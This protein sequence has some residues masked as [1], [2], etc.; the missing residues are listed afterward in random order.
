M[1]RPRTYSDAPYLEIRK[2]SK[3]G[4]RSGARSQR[5]PIAIS[6]NVTPMLQWPEDDLTVV[7]QYVASSVDQTS[8]CD[9]GFSK[10]RSASRGTPTCLRLH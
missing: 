4:C 10:I 5:R 1:R 8:R 9:V 2:T 6:G 3:A 7:L